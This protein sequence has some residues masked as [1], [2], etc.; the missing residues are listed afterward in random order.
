MNVKMIEMMKR[1]NEADEGGSDAG[2]TGTAV[3]VLD[4]DEEYMQKSEEERARLRGDVA[5]NPASPATQPAATAN[6]E[7][8]QGQASQSTDGDDSDVTGNTGGGIP[9]IRFNEVND[10]RKALEQENEQLRA[11]LASTQGHSG[12][13]SQGAQQ[14]QVQE[15][16]A[17]YNIEAA[18]ERYLQLVLDGDTK[19]ATK[20][21]ME[22][23]S[24]LQDAAY[25]R[26][27]QESA[28][29]QQTADAQKTVANLLQSYP[30]LDEPEGAEALDLIEASV[31]MK[32]SRG[33]S[34]A[35]ALDEAVNA[36]APRFAPTTTPPRVVQQE[37]SRVDIRVQRANERGAH[38][39]QLQPAQLQAGLG[40]RATAPQID[41]TKLTDE[42]YEA[43][44]EAERKKLR[45]DT[46]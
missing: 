1:L 45:G 25:S 27:A 16:A 22:I 11:Q 10:R 12:T 3:D 40:N 14:Q 42:E 38:D 44:P 30:W 29:Q 8:Q 32:V 26:F 7:E 9:R 6:G 19:A 21:R 17:P 20:L 4:S 15:N 18:E 46:I 24:V 23:N 41:G 43:L 33:V 28:A 35:Q 5:G 37:G 34:R 31:A 36:I 39:S 13:P 2:G